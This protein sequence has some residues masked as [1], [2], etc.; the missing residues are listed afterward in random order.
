MECLIDA[1]MANEIRSFTKK[2]TDELDKEFA[3]NLSGW[4]GSNEDILPII[5]HAK[6]S[7]SKQ[8]IS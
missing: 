6:K 4:R 8:F 1:D 5:N 3:S 2:L 7:I